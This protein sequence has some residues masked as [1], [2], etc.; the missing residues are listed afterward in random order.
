MPFVCELSFIISPVYLTEGGS[1][2]GVPLEMHYVRKLKDLQGKSDWEYLMI[3]RNT[4]SP[5]P[6]KQSGLP[7]NMARITLIAKT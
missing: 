1:A 4:A 3:A 7:K 6:L 2:V 5:L